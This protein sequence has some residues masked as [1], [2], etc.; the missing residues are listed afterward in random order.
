MH[1]NAE[2]EKILA[3]LHYYINLFSLIVL[4]GL[5]AVKL[6]V[7]YSFKTLILIILDR[8]LRFSFYYA[9]RV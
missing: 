2:I 8:F 6:M 7:N 5:S 3:I 1:F 4:N 9:L